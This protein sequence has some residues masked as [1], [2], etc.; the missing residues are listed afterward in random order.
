MRLW[1]LHPKYLDAKGI[2]ALWRE[3]LLARTVL[4]SE[5]KGYTNH[6]QLLRFKKQPDPIKTIDG[7]LWYVYQE[8]KKREYKFNKN[9]IEFQAESKKIEI[10]DQQIIHEL[11]H[12]KKKLRLRDTEKYRELDKVKV[13]LP[14]PIFKV[15][16]GKIEPW[17]KV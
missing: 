4:K 5:T 17:E 2:V 16:K 3:G 9:K 14:N 12:L 13:P 8:A 6:P 7:Y 1:S 15:V 11:K 10:T